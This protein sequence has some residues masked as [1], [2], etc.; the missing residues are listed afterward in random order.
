DPD[1]WYVTGSLHVN[2][3]RPTPLSN[4]V[5]LRGRVVEKGERRTTV[6]CSL[7]SDEAECAR[8]ELVAVR[9][10]AQAWRQGE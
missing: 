1:I 2:Y 9:V 8:S 6:A 10:D 4:P 5:T 3:L 7:Y